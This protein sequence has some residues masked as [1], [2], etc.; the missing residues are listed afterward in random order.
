[1]KRIF[2]GGETPLDLSAILLNA[3]PREREREG[4][5]ESERESGRRIPEALTNQT[6][7]IDSLYRIT[8][9]LEMC[10]TITCV[11]Y[12]LSLVSDPT[13]MLWHTKLVALSIF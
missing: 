8:T 4:M 1:M 6:S 12:V 9:V 2:I 3:N 10:P 13:P 11:T 7:S 5:R